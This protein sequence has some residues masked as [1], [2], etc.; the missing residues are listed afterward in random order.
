[1]KN[2][3]MSSSSKGGDGYTEIIFKTLGTPI[4]LPAATPQNYEYYSLYYTNRVIGHNPIVL[5]GNMTF[6]Y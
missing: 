2:G 6:I 5:T 1:M 3:E 4:I